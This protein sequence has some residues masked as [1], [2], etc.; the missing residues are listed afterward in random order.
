[1]PCQKESSEKAVQNPAAEP[2]PQLIKGGSL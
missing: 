1:M 2:M